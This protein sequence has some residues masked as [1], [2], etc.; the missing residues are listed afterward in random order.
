MSLAYR[1]SIKCNECFQD[2]HCNYNGICETTEKNRNEGRCRCFSNYFGSFCQ[3]EQ[4]CNAIRTEKDKNI[5]LELLED[6]DDPQGEDFV[7]NYGRPMYVMRNLSGKP[8]NLLRLGY[9]EDGKEYF[10]ITYA[11]QIGNFTPHKHYHDSFF[12]D[13]DFFKMKNST[14]EFS[15]LLQNYTFVLRF[16]GQR[17]YGEIIRPGLTAE[18]FEEEEYHGRWLLSL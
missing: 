4:P 11:N 8:Y 1:I 9:P 10:N 15:E 6:P 3:H 5:T 2:S 13:D 12:E 14:G 17:W 18:G 7:E 16:T